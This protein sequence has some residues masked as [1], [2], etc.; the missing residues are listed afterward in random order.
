MDC[1]LKLRFSKEFFFALP[2]IKFGSEG[3]LN[4][5]LDIVCGAGINLWTDT[6]CE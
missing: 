2:C 5:V 3:N 6:F 4:V 1:L